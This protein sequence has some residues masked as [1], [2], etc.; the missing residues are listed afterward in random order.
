MD[1]LHV[2]RGVSAVSQLPLTKTEPECRR[3]NV[4]SGGS[5]VDLEGAK[6]GGRLK[7]QRAKL[8]KIVEICGHYL[9]LLTEEQA[10]PRGEGVLPKPLDNNGVG[11]ESYF[12][13]ENEVGK[14]G[15]ALEARAVVSMKVRQY[16]GVDIANIHVYVG[17]EHHLAD[18]V[19]AV[20]EDLVV[21]ALDKK[22]AR[23][24]TLGKGITNT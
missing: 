7:I 24:E 17:L 16:N 3:G 1:Q 4:V 23:I 9:T 12:S 15:K 21:I 18:W 19:R 2:K 13:L 8:K 5:S 20:D 10:H 14:V 11:H 6:R 22:A